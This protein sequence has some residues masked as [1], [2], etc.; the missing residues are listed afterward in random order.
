MCKIYISSD[1]DCNKNSGKCK[2]NIENNSFNFGL[3]EDP[4][5][6][7]DREIEDHQE[8]NPQIVDQGGPQGRQLHDRRLLNA[9]DRY[10]LPVACIADTVPMTFREA[11]SSLDA[12]KWR[13]VDKAN[14]FVGMKIKRD[15]AK[16][17][18]K[19]SQPSYITK[20]IAKFG[21]E[22]ANLSSVPSEPGLHLSKSVCT[23]KNE[24]MPYRTV[25]PKAEKAG[26]K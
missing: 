3:E 23:E 15:R 7:E 5:I 22:N 18:L 20:A 19:V 12:E 6:E 25:V 11:M 16:R 17:A 21:M 14:E 9:P 2:K 4:E 24:C 1:V 8:A 26:Q 10:G 13:S